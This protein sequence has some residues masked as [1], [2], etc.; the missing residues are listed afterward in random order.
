[1]HSTRP[2]W[3]QFH[4]FPNDLDVTHKLADICKLFCKFDVADIVS[5]YLLEVFRNDA[6]HKSEATFLLNSMFGGRNDCDN[7]EKGLIKDVIATYL[8]VEHWNLGTV[9]ENESSLTEIRKN[10]LQVCLQTEGIGILAVA[11]EKD[12]DVF[13][14]KSL[15]LIL[16]RAGWLPKIT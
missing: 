8:E 11:L 13:L 10:I 9:V 5:D 16:E 3:Q 12:F 15:Y 1:M 2:Q 4:Y 7:K 6:E 14:L